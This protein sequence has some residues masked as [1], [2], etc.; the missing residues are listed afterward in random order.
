MLIRPA[1]L[2]L[3]VGDAAGNRR[4]IVDQD[5]TGPGTT[6]TISIAALL[7]AKDVIVEGITVATGD[8]WLSEEVMHVL[9]LLELLNRTDIPVL[10]A[11]EH[12]FTVATATDIP[13]ES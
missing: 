6:N 3:L 7:C 4:V 13:A 9:R 2:A 10:G 1:L 5:T 8:G 12:P 11:F